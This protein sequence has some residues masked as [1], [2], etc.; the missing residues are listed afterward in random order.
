MKITCCAGDGVVSKQL[1]YDGTGVVFAALAALVLL[2]PAQAQVSRWASPDE[3]VA[4]ALIELEHEWTEAGCTHNGIE[5]TIL[6]EDFHG[7][8]PDGTPYS[9]QDAV[10]KAVNAKTSEREC[11]TYEV[12]V[13]FFGENMAILYGSESAVHPRTDGREHTVKLTWT[14]TWLKREGKWQVVAAEDMPTDMK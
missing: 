10:E 5:K 3:P 12:K 2:I 14:D 8:N 4:K 9:K 1:S 7:I 11:R 13:H 6:A